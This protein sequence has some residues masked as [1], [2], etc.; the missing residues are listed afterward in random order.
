MLA[1]PRGRDAGTLLS[2]ADTFQ[3]VI[4]GLCRCNQVKIRS[5]GTR[6]ALNA[7]TGVLIRDEDERHRHGREATWKQW[8]RLEGCGHTPRASWS[9]RSWKRQGERGLPRSLWERSLWYS[10]T[11]APGHTHK[12]SQSADQDFLLCHPW[13]RLFP[14]PGRRIRLQKV[15]GRSSSPPG[16]MI[17][18][19]V[20][21]QLGGFLAR[22]SCTVHPLP[23]RGVRKR[24]PVT[25]E[26][27]LGTH[28]LWEPSSPPLVS[29]H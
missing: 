7:M 18:P 29:E 22:Q 15:R 6:V 28:K 8:Q 23:P 5:S 10:V 4:E 1:L 19:T 20:H 25:S 11:D 21:R 14:E 24:S 13:T 12:G 3:R 2:A 27:S 9:P 26:P 16:Q 17:R